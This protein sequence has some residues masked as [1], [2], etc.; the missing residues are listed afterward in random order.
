METQSHRSAPPIQS[1]NFKRLLDKSVDDLKNDFV[2]GARELA[3]TALSNLSS[4]IEAAGRAA[5]S[6]N[7]LWHAAVFAVRALCDAR[8]SMNAAVTSCLLRALDRVKGAWESCEGAEGRMTVE[9]LAGIAIQECEDMLEGRWKT[10]VRLGAHFVEYITKHSKVITLRINTEEFP[11]HSNQHPNHTLT[12]LTLS[13]SSTI[14]SCLYTLLTTLPEIKL[15]LHIL[16]SR[17]R[18]EGADL[19]AQLIASLP[20]SSHSR[21]RIRIFP[22][23]AVGPAVRDVDF[24]LLGADRIAPSGDV[25]NKI[26]SLGVAVMARQEQAGTRAQVVVISEVDKIAANDAHGTGE[27]VEVHPASE[28]MG[29]WAEETRKNLG[30]KMEKEAIDVFGEWFEWV[31][32]RYLDVYVTDNGVLSTG[33]VEAFSQ[34]IAD[35]SDKILGQ[36][37]L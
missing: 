18:C 7:N 29:A 36:A 23:C 3:S 32:A 25:S 20:T 10:G 5:E 4:L 30:G 11:S 14:R 33:D 26:G 9:G 13:N 2:S 6:R 15:T 37:V 31:P 1:E 12:L 17:P 8:P 21:L 27:N 22:D 28:L 24:V 34:K 19:A 35:L 16:E